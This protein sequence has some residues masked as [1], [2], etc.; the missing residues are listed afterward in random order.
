MGPLPSIFRFL[1][2]TNNCD[3]MPELPNHPILY[4]FQES[5]MT[6]PS[7]S[8]LFPAT[9]PRPHRP[10]SPLWV[11]AACM[12][13]VCLGIGQ[14]QAFEYPYMP[15]DPQPTGWPLTDAQREYLRKPEHERRP[16]AP[17]KHLPNLWP[18]V[19]FAQ[20]WGGDSYADHHDALVKMVQSRKGPCDVL[21]VGDSITIQ[22]EKDLAGNANWSLNFP[23]YSAV[24]IGV[25]GDRTHSVL[26][27]LDHGGADGLE[28]KVIVL[29]IGNNNQYFTA[30]TGTKAIAEG[31]KTCAMRL[32]A[33]FP[34]TPIV[35]VKILPC[36]KPG[37]PFYENIL[38]TN[39]D[40]DHVGIT[41][42]PLVQVLD[43]SKELL[44]AD[45]T[46]KEELYATDRIHLSK[47]GY[48]LYADRLRPILKNL[49]GK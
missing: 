9:T 16:G 37:D 39:A 20:S 32:R 23:D 1:Q 31:I 15:A 40:L 2:S 28:P 46:I 3:M 36:S 49:L 6:N 29:M 43:F 25:G 10:M 33:Q 4:P 11:R 30:E 13:L 14:L 24:N 26:W 41:E 12:A 48:A 47:A 34:K 22:F 8:R 45:G 35:V 44:N 19:P 38:K 17:S 27:R 18:S 7:S 42:D 21:L 5:P